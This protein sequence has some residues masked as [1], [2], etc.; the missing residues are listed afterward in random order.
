[1][2][3]WKHPYFKL[4]HVNQWNSK[5]YSD[6]PVISLHPKASWHLFPY[7]KRLLPFTSSHFRWYFQQVRS[8]NYIILSH[9]N[10]ASHIWA[11][12]WTTSKIKAFSVSPSPTNLSSPN[13]YPYTPTTPFNLLR[14]YLEPSKC[15]ST[16]KNFPLQ[17]KRNPPSN[18]L[19]T[20][21]SRMLR[22]SRRA[23]ATQNR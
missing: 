20:C 8:K 2:L 16:K 12:T 11:N 14:A 5:I 7:R 13:F 22:E 4:G 3:A 18:V 6:L 15:K 23:S 19:P 1:M 21:T 17:T 9:S 10:P